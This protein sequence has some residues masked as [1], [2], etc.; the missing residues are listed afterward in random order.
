MSPFVYIR[1][2]FI[3]GKGEKRQK[4]REEVDYYDN[5]SDSNDENDSKTNENVEK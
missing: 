3:D 2:G 1:N 5:D 4:L